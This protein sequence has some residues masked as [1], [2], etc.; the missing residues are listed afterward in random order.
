MVVAGLIQVNVVTKVEWQSLRNVSL[1]KASGHKTG[2]DQENVKV[3]LGHEFLVVTQLKDLRHPFS[4]EP[5]DIESQDIA[6][7]HRGLNKER[8]GAQIA[9]L[10]T[11]FDSRR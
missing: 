9:R 1:A 10:K 2:C 11:M 7:V 5:K 8:G 4:A 6:L 3:G